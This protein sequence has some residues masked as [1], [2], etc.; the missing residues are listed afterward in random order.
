MN[1]FVPLERV[2]AEQQKEI[3]RLKS[4]DRSNRERWRRQYFMEEAIAEAAFGLLNRPNSLE[5]AFELKQSLIAIG[6][7]PRC[8]CKPCHCDD[9]VD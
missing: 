7:C 9:N 6:Y 4:L 8:Q 2:I 5:Y 3:D 1:D